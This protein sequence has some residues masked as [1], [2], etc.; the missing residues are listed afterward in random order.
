M[1]AVNSRREALAEE[2][3]FWMLKLLGENPR[4]SQRELSK[5]LGISLGAVNYCLKA[6]VVKGLLKMQNF[7]SSERK[8]GYAYLLTPQGAAEKAALTKRFLERKLREFERLQQEIEALQRSAT[9]EGAAA[10]QRDTP[11]KGQK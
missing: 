6:L 3:N 2:T 7:Q 4:A 5:G 9:A 10:S 11:S 8:I 1:P